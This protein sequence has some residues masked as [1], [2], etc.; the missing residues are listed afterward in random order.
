MTAV[1]NIPPTQARFTFH[2]NAFC[3]E[4]GLTQ[5]VFYYDGWRSY[6]E[7]AD[8]AADT[9]CPNCEA[10]RRRIAAFIFNGVCLLRGE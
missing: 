7:L 1:L 8:F 5:E 4:R 6:S 9:L 10:T 3:V 2:R